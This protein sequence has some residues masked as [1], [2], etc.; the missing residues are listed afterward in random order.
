MLLDLNNNK[1]LNIPVIKDLRKKYNKNNQYNECFG[2]NDKFIAISFI[3]RYLKDEDIIKN[4]LMGLNNTGFYSEIKMNVANKNYDFK[5]MI[6]IDLHLDGII[7]PELINNIGDVTFFSRDIDVII[8]KMNVVLE[9]I[10]KFILTKKDI[11]KYIIDNYAELNTDLIYHNITSTTKEEVINT[12]N[13]S[14]I[15]NGFLIKNEFSFAKILIDIVNKT[16]FY[17]W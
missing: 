16:I 6:S 2:Y 7:K 17:R 10:S 15:I 14:E 11:K 13:I 1:H 5:Q 8:K 9:R 3:E 4:K 12:S